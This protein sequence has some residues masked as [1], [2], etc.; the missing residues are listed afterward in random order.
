MTSTIDEFGRD[1]SLRS[2]S[3][4]EAYT[5]EL[6]ISNLIKVMS[7]MSWA[8]FVFEKED[9]EEKQLAA[10]KKRLATEQRQKR[11]AEQPALDAIAKHRKALL[12][13]GLYELEEGEE[14]E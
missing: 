14:L 7:T 13:K 6:Y 11:L 9:E 2:K 8:E 4:R 10:Q 5:S 12:S 3:V 1:Y